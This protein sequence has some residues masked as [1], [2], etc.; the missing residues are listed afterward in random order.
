MSLY[1]YKNVPVT[2]NELKIWLLDKSI[3]PRTKRK[4]KST[5]PI[6]KYLEDESIKNNLSGIDNIEEINEN[7]EKFSENADES[8]QNLEFY[9]EA[10]LLELIQDFQGPLGDD[11]TKSID[12]KDPI[13]QEDIW[14]IEDGQKIKSKEIPALKMFSYF[15]SS[16][17]IRAFNIESIKTMIE[18]NINRHPI[19][20]EIIDIEILDRAQKMIQVLIEK[21]YLIVKEDN[22]EL[23]ETKIKNLAFDVF[24]NFN[25]ISIFVDSEWFLKLNIDELLKLNYELKDFYEN[26]TDNE[27]RHIMVPPDGKVFCFTNQQ[28]KNEC[29]GNKLNIQKYLLDDINKV[30]TSSDNEAIKNLGNYL[31]IGGLAV[32]CPEIRDRYPDFVYSFNF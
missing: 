5:S 26:N 18:G 16:D 21:K 19:T 7:D 28:L 12:N 13:S 29:Q 22:G 32:V 11:Y 23:T 8:S 4:I 14:Y 1:R 2:I 20:N 27:T 30:I 25:V 9:Q 3:N 15:D 10:H 17:N 31:M 24:Q 6:Y